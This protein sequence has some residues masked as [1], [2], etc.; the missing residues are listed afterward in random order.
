MKEIVRIIHVHQCPSV[1][2]THH[3]LAATFFTSVNVITSFGSLSSERIIRL[4]SRAN[5]TEQIKM[6]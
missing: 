6:L 5:T 3:A 1:V 4:I 2:K